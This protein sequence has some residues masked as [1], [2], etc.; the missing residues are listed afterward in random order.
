MGG[1]IAALVEGFARHAAGVAV[2]GVIANR[3][4]GEGHR[5]ILAG[6]L[7]AS[8]VP[9][10]G[11]LPRD[12]ALALPSR[13]LGLVQARETGGL[14]GIVERAADAIAAHVDIAALRALATPPNSRVTSWDEGGKAGVGDGQRRGNG[15]APPPL[16]QRIAVARDVAF[17][18]AYPA[19]L[20]AWRGAGADLSFFSP[21]ADEAP[22]RD[23][24]AVYLPGGY[25][26]LHAGRLAAN[27]GFL[28]GLRAA[29]GW[30]AAVFGECGGYMVLGRALIDAKGVSHAMAGLLPHVASF[31]EPRLHL[32]YRAMRVA[33]DGPLG[34]AGTTYRGHEFHYASVAGAEGVPLFHAWEASGR[35]LGP[36]GSVSGRVAGSFLH[37]IDGA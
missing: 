19:T 33:A 15:L 7:A 17:A 23:T 6:A 10:L 29:A 28:E 14:E 34:P 9:L 27:R 11:A 36:M 2:A 26:E 35:D 31:S 25:P 13:H 22:G 12:A 8:G 1:S 5:A 37:L 24:D 20:A 18:F 21:L 16:G 3:T 32:G 4:G 30:G